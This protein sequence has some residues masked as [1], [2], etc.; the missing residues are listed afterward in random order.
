MRKCGLVAV[1]YGG[2]GGG[3]SLLECMYMQGDPSIATE[4][5]SFCTPSCLTI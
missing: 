1:A 5:Q 4:E 2:G 3:T